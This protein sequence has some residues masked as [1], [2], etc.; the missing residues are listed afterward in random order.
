MPRKT[1]VLCRL[2]EVLSPFST[3]CQ[4]AAVLNVHLLRPAMGPEI[5]G[6]VRKKI[7]RPSKTLPPF[8]S[9]E[10]LLLAR[11]ETTA[12]GWK[13]D[14]GKTAAKPLVWLHTASRKHP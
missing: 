5:A 12:P 1:S 3:G 10:E 2:R 7:D 8:R 11:I 6:R 9:V 14:C 13:H 4:H